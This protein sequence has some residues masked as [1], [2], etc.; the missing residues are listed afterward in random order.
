MVECTPVLL[1]MIRGLAAGSQKLDGL[2]IGA[3]TPE[4]GLVGV[5]VQQHSSCLQQ[6]AKCEEDEP[7]FR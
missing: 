3:I 4:Q 5:A 7:R 6:N 1:V 2:F